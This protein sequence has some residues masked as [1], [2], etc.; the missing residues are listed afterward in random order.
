MRGICL[1]PAYLLRLTNKQC[2]PN[3]G[4]RGDFVALFLKVNLV[5]LPLLLVGCDYLSCFLDFL[6]A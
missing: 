6:F 5:S 3:V 1:H 4:K 2:G